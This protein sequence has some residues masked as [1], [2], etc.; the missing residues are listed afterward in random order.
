MM[1][2]IGLVIVSLLIGAV[3]GYFWAEHSDGSQHQHNPDAVVEFTIPDTH[4]PSTDLWYVTV[5]GQQTPLAGSGQLQV[6]DTLT[7]STLY[8]TSPYFDEEHPVSIDSFTGQYMVIETVPSLDTPVCT[9]QTKQLEFAAKKFPQTQFL[10][11][12]NDTPFAL[13]RFCLENSIDN[14]QTLSDARTSDFARANKLLMTDYNLFARTIMV[15]DQNQQVLYIDYADEV[16]DQVDILNALAF[17]ESLIN[18]Q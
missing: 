6:G 7:L 8:G 12:S 1:Y 2:R 10:V 4:K 16:T 15:V 5:G 9:L 17:L 3:S 18:Q 13:K 11:L 14:L